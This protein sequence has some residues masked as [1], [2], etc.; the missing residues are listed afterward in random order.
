MMVKVKIFND[1]L[2]FFQYI[3]QRRKEWDFAINFLNLN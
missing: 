3:L 1:L 2:K